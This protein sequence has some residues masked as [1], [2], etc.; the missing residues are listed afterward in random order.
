MGDP[1]EVIPTPP[2]KIWLEEFAASCSAVLPYVKPPPKSENAVVTKAWNQ[3]LSEAH[4][5]HYE[6]M[7]LGA[8]VLWDAVDRAERKFDEMV[9]EENF[10]FISS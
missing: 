10:F 3:P 8:R 6:D 5:N 1:R 7:V 9:C 2:E 4:A